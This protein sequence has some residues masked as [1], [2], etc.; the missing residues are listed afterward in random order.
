MSPC[1][2]ARDNANCNR[3]VYP[4]TY[5]RPV[6]PVYSLQMR[7]FNLQ[8]KTRYSLSF[9]MGGYSS[10]QTATAMQAYY[11]IGDSSG[12]AYACGTNTYPSICHDV[13]TTGAAKGQYIQMNF[14]YTSDKPQALN[15]VVYWQGLSNPVWLL[16][17]I[18]I[19]AI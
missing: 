9:F 15:F 13:S 6:T 5:H 14:T 12:S 3:N 18:E 4:I 2:Q 16:D 7:T 19:K 11:S 8:D 1:R 10:F 17:D